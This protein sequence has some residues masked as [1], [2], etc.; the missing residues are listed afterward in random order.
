M[1]YNNNNKLIVICG[2]TAVGKTSLA[3]DLSNQF[4]FEIISVDSL[5]VYKYLDIGQN[6]I[7]FW[8]TIS[9]SFSYIPVPCDIRIFC[10][11]L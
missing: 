6:H 2:P 10:N 8:S 1:S 9:D 7:F 11:T 4:P 3:I 5:L